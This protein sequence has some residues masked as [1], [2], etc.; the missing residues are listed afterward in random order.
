MTDPGTTD[1][2]L[3]RLATRADQLCTGNDR[4]E[5]NLAV[6]SAVRNLRSDN[7][8]DLIRLFVTSGSW[9]DYQYPNGDRYQF[10][11]HEFDYFL[12]Q[13]D[14]DP[15]LVADAAVHCNDHE[16]RALLVEA[17][18]DT[19]DEHRRSIPDIVATYPM[20]QSWLTKYGQRTLGPTAAYQHTSARA[21][22]RT[23]ASANSA[24][25]QTFWKVTLTGDADP[26]AA[27]AAKLLAH[28]DLLDRVLAELGRF[29]DQASAFDPEKR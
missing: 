12:A 9:R 27:I 11:A 7:I 18:L 23:G 17:S 26:A 19:V 5:F 22:L 14:I 1:R 4:G 10:R 21:A 25:R 8:V 2:W 6:R 28:P 3:H 13:Q 16:L 15:R 29:P 20:L 24:R